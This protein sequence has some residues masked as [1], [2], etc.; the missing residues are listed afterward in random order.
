MEKLFELERVYQSEEFGRLLMEKNVFDAR[1][2]LTS[3]FLYFHYALDTYK[4]YEY[5]SKFSFGS[6]GLFIKNFDFCG[7]T[8][9]VNELL[10][11][12]VLEWV[13]H[14]CNSTDCL[15]QFINAALCLGLENGNVYCGTVFKRIRDHDRYHAIFQELE[16]LSRDDTLKHIRAICNCNKHSLNLYGGSDFYGACFNKSRDI[17]IPA[18]RHKGNEY[19]KIGFSALAASFDTFTDRFINVVEA[20]RQYVSAEPAREHRWY[21][22]Q[23]LIDGMQV[24]ESF[25]DNSVLL[26]ISTKKVD[27]VPLV[28][29][30][31][32]D[33]P[34]FIL[35]EPIEIMFFDKEKKYGQYLHHVDQ[36]DLFYSGQ[37][38]GSLKR[39]RIKHE[40]SVLAY[41]KYEFVPTKRV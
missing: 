30:L 24:G 36:I 21:C 3:S 6:D 23:L 22:S 35:T 16:P 29:G 20:T 32:I 18:F 19:G 8:F 10:N 26:N 37:K 17:I 14:I 41:Q 27:D 25:G 9:N 33:D 7:G 39:V 11:K 15:A 34:P 1:Q 40:S 5:V 12:F 13:S 28:S 4:L 38:K 2:F 31:W